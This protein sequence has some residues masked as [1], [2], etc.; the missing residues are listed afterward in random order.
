MELRTV[1]ITG[2]GVVSPVGI[3]KGEFWNSLISGKS[4]IGPISSF[5][6]A[7]FSTKFA[8]EVNNFDP[9]NYMSKKDARRFDRVIQ[10]SVASAALS[11]E[12]SGLDLDKIDRGRTGVI[13]SSG[14]GG[15]RTWG[16]QY[17]ILLGQGPRRIS[18]V[19]IPNIIPNMSAGQV[20]IV[21]GFNGPNYCVSSACASGNH[22]ILAAAD[23]IRLNR[24]DIMLAGGS[25]AGV[26][27]ICV[28]GFSNMHALS[29]RNDEP[30]KASRPFD[31]ERD[32]FVLGEG[33]GIMILEELNHALERGAH[34]YAILAGGGS[35]SD[36]HHMTA[37]DPEGK[38][39]IRAMRFALESAET[40]PEEVDYINAHGTST[41]LGDVAETKAIKEVFG[42]HAYKLAVSSTKSMTGHLLGA[43][44][45][46]ESI[47][48]ALTIDSGII[49]PTVNYE[50]PDPDC[51]LD[52]V[53][54]V[55]RKADVKVAL[56]N[57][58]GFGGQNAVALFRKYDR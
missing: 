49:A 8:A 28:A 53:P 24:A 40:K 32:G 1:A 37:P 50:F 30:G 11:L 15:I 17:A 52:Y 29:S 4:G 38:G 20:S 25:E 42:E 18:P 34:I 26:V 36:A 55:A 33:A 22:A 44:A 21:Y 23:Q 35:T 56:N 45:A 47:V 46:L 5:D 16:E 14:I 6:T 54:N 3:G 19:F 13:I 31:K 58:F 2:I 10:F 57:S 7:E 41:P 12:D 51:D 48:C 39:A 9:E 27:P 43:A